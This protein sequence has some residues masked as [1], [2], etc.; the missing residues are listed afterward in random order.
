MINGRLSPLCLCAM[1]FS[2]ISHAADT[3]TSKIMISGQ[4]RDNACAVAA[5]STHV[6]V[7]LLVNAAKQLSSTGA[8]TPP[9]P[10]SI[11]LAPCGPAAKNVKVG[12]T[13]TPDVDNNALLALD[14]S[15][16]SS[17]RGM[18]IQ[19]LD[20]SKTA[21]DLNAVS[22]MQQWIPLTGGQPNTLNFFARLMATGAVSAGTVNAI[23]D[24][25]LEFQ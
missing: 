1:L 5:T 4:I 20:S 10:F 19:L 13:G 14:T 16:A 3:S 6:D 17:A 22:A 7:D 11:E 25:T 9:V 18:G 15:S 23:A 24:F 8:T 12:F 2:G 21:I